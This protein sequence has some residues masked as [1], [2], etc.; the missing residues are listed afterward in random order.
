MDSFSQVIKGGRWLRIWGRQNVCPQHF[1]LSF[2]G[3]CW[4]QSWEWGWRSGGVIAL[5]CMVVL[6]VCVPK[7]PCWGVPGAGTLGVSC[8]RGTGV[9]SPL[10]ACAEVPSPC[11]HGTRVLGPACAAVTH[12]CPQSLSL[13]CC[14]PQILSSWGPWCPVCRC[15]DAWSLSPCR[16]DIQTPSCMYQCSQSPFPHFQGLWSFACVCW[17]PWSPSV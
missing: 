16:W 4:P 15:W 11:P 5:G 8:P 2:E 6:R 14:S 13:M 7:S 17:D 9:P 12:S 1:G 10:P 3:L